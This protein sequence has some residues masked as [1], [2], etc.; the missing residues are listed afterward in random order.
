[1]DF[2]QGQYQLELGSGCG[3]RWYVEDAA[4]QTKQRMEIN[5]YIM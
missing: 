5:K 3:R 4:R 2:L 1:M